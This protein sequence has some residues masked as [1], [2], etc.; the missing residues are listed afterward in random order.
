M[1]KLSLFSAS[2]KGKGL[3]IFSSKKYDE[4][5]RAPMAQMFWRGRFTVTMLLLLFGMLAASFAAEHVLRYGWTPATQAWLRIYMDNFIG[6]FGLSVFAEFP[7]W[8]TR[9]L[10][11]TDIYTIFPVI[12]FIAFFALHNNAFISE[13]NPYDG[14]ALSKKSSRKA[15]EAD[16][17]KMGTKGGS[18][19]E[20][21]MMVLGKFKGKFV[22][23]NETLSVLCVAPPGTGKT[24]GIVM[25]TLFECDTVS[26]IVNDPKPEIAKLT[27]GY[28]STIG[29]VFIIDWAGQDDPSRG[30]YYP[31]WNPLSPSHIPT[32]MSE[33][34]LYVDTICNVMIGETSKEMHWTLTGRAALSGFIHFMVSKI[35]RARANDWFLARIRSQTFDAEDA[36]LLATYYEPMFDP[37]SQAALNALQ[38]GQKMTEAN[39]VPI[40]TWASIPK[41]WLGK[42][43]SLSMIFDWINTSQLEVAAK[44]EARRKQGDQMVAL[45]DSMKEVFQIAVNEARQFN[46]AHRAVLELTQIANTPDKERGSILS[47]VFSSLGIFRNSAVRARTSHSDFNFRDLRGMV[48]P[49]DGKMKPVTVYLSV[50]Q[51]DALALN[52]I[53]GIFVELMSNFLIS[54]PPET[55]TA[56]GK[57]G[58]TPV[59]FVL[60]E[61]PKMVKLNAVVEGPSVGRGQQV[62]YLMIGQDLEQIAAGYSREAMETLM[63]TTAA[64]IVL[65]QNS[66]K[67]AEF[68]SHMMGDKVELDDEGKAKTPSPLYSPMDI[69]TLDPKKEIIIVQGHANRPIEADLAYW[70]NDDGLKK[71]QAVPASSALPEFL[72]DSHRRA[73][74]LPPLK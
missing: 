56:E 13:F 14:D 35:E 2:G 57:L 18:L 71:K 3:G 1:A 49:K 73:I 22:K 60:D 32:D 53:T 42:E 34:E 47:T 36:D 63:S 74:G 19:F 40:G 31:S 27:S 21:F 29:P 62:S 55:P 37:N 26:M 25:P 30:I 58:P 52:P 38:A 44:M 4:H 61:F 5:K 6:S 45:E 66:M 28:R 59:L 50:N 54:N 72:I 11:R 69:I 51:V 9:T 65:R 68:F 39:Y 70:F 8:A 33:R 41:Q 43:A 12:S 46:Y 20:G 67:T 10:L 24:T 15:T 17:K 48:D 7:S 64:K 23:L 16:V